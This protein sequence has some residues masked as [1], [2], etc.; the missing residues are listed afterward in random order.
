MAAS[1]VHQQKV[2][3][4]ER[5]YAPTERECLAVVH[6]LTKWGRYLHGESFTAVSDHLSIK[7][8]L[9][10]K[11]PSEKLAR[12]VIEIQDFDFRIETSQ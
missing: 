8:L 5:N 4:T 6:A 12:W 10:L 2:E 3:K 7:W 1:G 9:S 11:D